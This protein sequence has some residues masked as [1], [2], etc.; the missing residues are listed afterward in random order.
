MKSQNNQMRK[1]QIASVTLA[2]FVCLGFLALPATA[3]A[4]EK[5]QGMAPV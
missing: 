1:D 3:F 2:L 4:G 5:A